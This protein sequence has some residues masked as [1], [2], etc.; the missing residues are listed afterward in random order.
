MKSGY[1]V[2]WTDHAL[3]ELRQTVSYLEENFSEREILRLANKIESILGLIATQ[4][5]MF[6]ESPR[7][8]GVRRVVILRLNSLYYRV[9]E[10]QIQILSFFSN[11]QD[12]KRSKF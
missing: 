1:K 2:V 4:P 11:R 6:P 3:D 5:E 10:R 9:N 12:P 8:K 7:R